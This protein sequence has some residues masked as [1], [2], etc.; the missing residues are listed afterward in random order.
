MDRNGRATPGLDISLLGAPRIRIGG[1]AL[2]VD[3]RKAIALLAFLAVRGEPVGRDRLA[4]LLWPEHPRTAAAGALR[5]TLSSLRKGLGGGWLIADRSS[6]SLDRTGVSVDVDRFR[7]LAAAGPSGL[8][9]AVEMY[10]SEFMEGFS[11]RDAPD[12]DDWQLLTGDELRRTL[13]GVLEQLSAHFAEV[14]DLDSALG[15]ARRWLALDPLHEPAHRRVMELLV[16]HGRRSEA[17]R[18]YRECVAIL[19]RELGVSPLTETTELYQA[20]ME[21]ASPDGLPAQA[22]PAVGDTVTPV[23]FVGR[24]RE[25]ERL[26]GLYESSDGRGLACAL[27]GEAGIGKTR[28][29]D[30]F[31]ASVRSSGGTVLESRCYEEERTL[32]FAPVV[33]VLNAAWNDHRDRL[34]SLPVHVLREAARIAPALPFDAPPARAGDRGAKS[35]LLNAVSEVLFATLDGHPPGVLFID[36]IHW[37]DSATTELLLFALRRLAGHRMIALFAWRPDEPGLQFPE[38]FGRLE[39]ERVASVF[40]LE[41]FG[42]DE[43]I[44]LVRASAPG[45]NDSRE[46]ATALFQQ[47]EGLPLFVVEFM[48]GGDTDTLPAGVRSLLKAR[49]APVGELGRQVLGTAAVMGR[50]FDFD[51]IRDASGRAEDEVVTALEELVAR[52]LIVEGSDGHVPVYEFGHDK[53]RELVYEEMGLARRRVLHRRIADALL[54]HHRARAESEWAPLVARH[55][56]LGGRE[57]QAADLYLLAGEHAASVSAHAEALANF[58]SALALTHGN[59]AHIHELIGDV[60]TLRGEYLAAVEA[61]EAAAALCPPNRLPAIEHKLGRL[62]YRRGDWELAESY[63]D[64]ALASGKD[65]AFNAGVSADWA[66]TAYHRGESDVALQLG[67]AAFRYAERS[68]DERALAQVHNVLGIIRS[69]AGD[70]ESAIEHLERSLALADSSADKPARVA[71]LNNLALTHRSMGALDVAKVLTEEGLA[72]CR[73]IGDRHRE[74]ALHNN[75][76]DLLRANGDS[77]AAM[78]HLKKAVAIFAEV[79]APGEM[80][81]E[82]WKLVEW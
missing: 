71:A 18:Q 25:R 78:V 55:Y 81:P 49:I 19:D 73:S 2:E 79:A 41:R 31:L 72:L 57:G 42:R 29:A 17:L 48:A 64:G 43:V 8:T 44:E 32:P 5:R 22:E 15:H 9:A 54:R 4:A 24:V 28:L 63:F 53:L 23:R 1:R 12:F 47:S 60:R 26:R 33:G 13:A 50:W 68:G 69:G 62:H 77:S 82:I 51:A 30:E 58:E 34:R 46:A 56:R 21:G 27:V 65:D 45:T 67:D 74:A 11:L 59:P 38:L 80:Q 37:A 6:V 14:R 76:A 70:T 7:T 52:G 35:R 20:I 3:T 61:Y 40:R 16:A 10:R 75:L 39:R 36:D 66:L